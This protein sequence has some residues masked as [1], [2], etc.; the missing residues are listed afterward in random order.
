[1]NV[2]DKV[3]V[4]GKETEITA[5]A[6]DDVGT[7]VYMV[8]GSMKDYYENELKPTKEFKN[9]EEIISLCIKEL[10]IGD[11]NIH[12]TLGF[13]ELKELQ[14]LL[15][16][17]SALEIH[18]QMLINQKREREKIIDLMAEYI[19]GTDKDEDICKKVGQNQL[20]GEY[21]ENSK[22]KECVIEYYKNKAKEMK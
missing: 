4:D 20:C 8:K 22:C 9:L 7:K 6:Y 17:K 1:M 12:A 13:E 18:T 14:N 3:L 19:S 10:Y 11:R 16:K 5:T 2:G 21:E 15:N